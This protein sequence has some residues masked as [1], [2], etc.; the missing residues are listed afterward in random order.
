MA[1]VRPTPPVAAP[2]ARTPERRRAAVASDRP[3]LPKATPWP[4][5]RGEWPT[6]C[7]LCFGALERC[8]AR[9]AMRGTAARVAPRNAC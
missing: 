1:T 8:P 2:D 6:H 4:S 7:P 3:R 9:A 5:R